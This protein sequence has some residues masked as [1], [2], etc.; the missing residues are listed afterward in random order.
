MIIPARNFEFSSKSVLGHDL[1]AE[2]FGHG[3]ID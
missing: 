2:C 1:E 3:L